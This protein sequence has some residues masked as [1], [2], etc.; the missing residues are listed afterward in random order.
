MPWR[1]RRE[2]NSG[3][4]WIGVDLDGTLA[5]Y[6]GWRGVEHIGDPVP[7]MLERVKGWIAEGIEVRIFTARICHPRKR[8]VAIK[9]INA[10]C[11]QHGLPRL[12]ITNVKDFQMLELWDD[13]AVRVETNAGTR[14]DEPAKPPRRRGK[15]RAAH[16]APLVVAAAPRVATMRT[17]GQRRG[18]G[19]E[20]RPS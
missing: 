4:N 17:K 7:A 1:S 16:K 10:W 12:A 18:E 8:R 6:H 2:P 20:Q 9:T 5:Y 13:R 11:A 3:G 15:K 14:T 19:L